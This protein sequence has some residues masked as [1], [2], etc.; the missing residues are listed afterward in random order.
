MKWVPTGRTWVE[1]G[2]EMVEMKTAMVADW[3][4]PVDWP[5]AHVVDTVDTMDEPAGVGM[6]ATAAAAQP[7][8]WSERAMARRLRG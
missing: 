5:A 2:E 1:G 4:N 7:G 8:K 3:S 6:I